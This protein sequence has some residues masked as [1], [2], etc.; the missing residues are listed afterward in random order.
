M[1]F[2]DTNYFLRFLLADI[3]RQHQEAKKLFLDGAAGRIKL[4]SSTIVF[5]EIYWVLSSYYHKKKEE[6]VPAL[7]DILRLAFRNNLNL[8]DCYNLCFAKNWQVKDFRTFDAA[9]AKKAKN[10]I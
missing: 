6:I 5:F 1:T 4:A 10:I 3:D 7:Q 2:V 9:L 8:E